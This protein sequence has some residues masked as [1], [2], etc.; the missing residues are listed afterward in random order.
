[1]KPNKG[2][3]GARVEMG[4]PTMLNRAGLGMVSPRREH[5]SRDLKVVRQ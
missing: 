3:G 4:E 1:M 5:W 2:L